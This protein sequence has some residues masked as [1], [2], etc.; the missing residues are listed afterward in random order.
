[1]ENT[2][3]AVDFI[4]LA[5]LVALLSE[6]LLIIIF[7]LGMSAIIASIYM[8]KRLTSIANYSGQDGNYGLIIFGLFGGTLMMYTSVSYDMLATSF[9]FDGSDSPFSYAGADQVVTQSDGVKFLIDK[10]MV[11]IG[12]YAIFIKG[13]WGL[14]RKSSNPDNAQGIGIT[15]FYI[16]FGFLAIQYKKVIESLSEYIPVL[17]E[18]SNII[19]TNAF[20]I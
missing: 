6:L 16:I 9:G 1:M 15:V 13:L 17:D 3:V 8:L 2:P 18:I 14:R 11:F 5:E 19:N 4:A 7:V 20:S 12:F 10:V